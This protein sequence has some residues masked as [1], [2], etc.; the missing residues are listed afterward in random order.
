MTIKLYVSAQNHIHAPK[1]KT[2]WPVFGKKLLLRGV[3]RLWSCYLASAG[4][5]YSNSKTHRKFIQ[6]IRKVGGK[7]YDSIHQV[8][9]T[10]PLGVV[11]RECEAIFPAAHYDIPVTG[12]WDITEVEMAGEA[13]TDWLQKYSRPIQVIAHLAGG[14]RRACE[15]AEQKLIEKEIGS[16]QI[17]FI[18]TMNPT[19]LSASSDSALSQLRE[20][21]SEIVKTYVQ[22]NA[23]E[24]QENNSQSVLNRITRDE[25]IVRATFDF[26]FG[27][28]V[29]DFVIEN[30]VVLN[31]AQNMRSDE[32]LTF[33]GAGKILIGNLMRDSGLVH[34]T[35][36]GGA[37]LMKQGHNIIHIG[38]PTIQGTTIFRPIFGD[39]DESAHPNDEMIV[40]NTE[41]QFLG[42]GSLTQAPTEIYTSLSGRI[43][44]LRKKQKPKG[45]KKEIQPPSEDGN[46]MVKE[47]L[48]D[49]F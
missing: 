13:L 34:L 40:L 26:Q 19:D 10:S 28:G 46:N 33:D 37:F 2:L 7:L 35:Q 30:S 8:I 16:D 47:M 22:Q 39:I 45:S 41:D 18:Y 43:C 3:T 31:Q 21:L 25:L 17:R 20:T 1:F 44:T 29:G 14:Y 15:Y 12:N 27:K 9:V 38:T 49:D 32:I 48:G 42:V 36:Q 11:P 4:K 6:I 5:P 24:E 23:A